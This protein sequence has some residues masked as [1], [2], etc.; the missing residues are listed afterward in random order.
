MRANDANKEEEQRITYIP[1]TLLWLLR[2]SQD[3]VEDQNTFQV[4]I[5][6]LFSF[7]LPIPLLPILLC[8]PPF[9]ICVIER[10]IESS[11]VDD[12]D[13]VFAKILIVIADEDC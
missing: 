13:C 11:R 6:V 12:D 9:G 2:R 8:F 4:T 1:E 10:F 7:L 3:Q 5:L